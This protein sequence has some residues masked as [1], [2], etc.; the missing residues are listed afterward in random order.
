M[1]AKEFAKV[2]TSVGTTVND[3]LGSKAEEY[4]SDVDRLHNFKTAAALLGDTPKQALAGMM[5]KHTVSIYDMIKSDKTYSLAVWDEKII[6]HI[7]Y[8]ILLKALV[9][10]QDALLHSLVEDPLHENDQK[11]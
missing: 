1:N 10:E 6:D 8:L 9:V 2:L 4:A 3:T 11:D 7:N 5:R